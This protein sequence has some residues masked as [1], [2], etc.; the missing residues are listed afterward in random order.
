[1]FWQQ[2]QFFV[3]FASMMFGGSRQP[4]RNQ[5]IDER[6]GRACRRMQLTVWAHDVHPDAHDNSRVEPAPAVTSG[7]F[8]LFVPGE[9]AVAILIARR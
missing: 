8:V 9:V 3:D 2:F 7:A 5:I 6:I 1:V 4:A